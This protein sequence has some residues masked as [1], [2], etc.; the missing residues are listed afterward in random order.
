M[1]KILELKNYFFMI[2]FELIQ[3]NSKKNCFNKFMMNSTLKILLFFTFIFLSHSAFS[4]INPETDTV[5]IE[6]PVK[7][8]EEKFRERLDRYR[9]KNKFNKFIHKLFIRNP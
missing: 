9:N 7:T 2:S 4:Q 1:Y 8:K 3:T 6:E 5:K